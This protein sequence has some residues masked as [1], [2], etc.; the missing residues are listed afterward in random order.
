MYEV[1]EWK[2][3]LFSGTRR[4]K[5]LLSINSNLSLSVHPSFH[6]LFLSVCCSSLTATH[7]KAAL[8]VLSSLLL[9]ANQLSVFSLWLASLFLT[10]L[11]LQLIPIPP[12]SSQSF[13]F[14]LPLLRVLKR[15]ISPTCTPLSHVVSSLFLTFVRW[16]SVLFHASADEDESPGCLFDVVTMATPHLFT[17]VR[18]LTS[19]S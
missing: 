10:P 11:S 1:C 15:F 8:S 16:K 18:P 14:V 7:S 17:C 9:C 5:T 12:S 19:N 6:L 4:A 13:L 3:L 2:Q